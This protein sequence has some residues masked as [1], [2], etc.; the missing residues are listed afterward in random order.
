M[1]TCYSRVPSVRAHSRGHRS[2]SYVSI[3]QHT[4]AY[5]SIRQHQAAYVS[6]RQHSQ[7]G[8]PPLFR[9]TRQH[10]SAYASIRQ[11]TSAYV[12]IRQHTPAYVSIRQHTSAYLLAGL[13]EKPHC[14]Q[15][16]GLYSKNVS[17]CTFVPAKQVNSV[18]VLRCTFVPVKQANSVP[19]LGGP[20]KLGLE[21]GQQLYFC[22]SKASKLSTGTCRATKAGT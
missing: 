8:A 10:S 13:V 22:T 15:R 6:I 4:S 19:V 11:H 16:I 12:S 2:Y 3:R 7:Q 1:S 17:S 9:R 18:P 21:V 5:V 20:L 14:P